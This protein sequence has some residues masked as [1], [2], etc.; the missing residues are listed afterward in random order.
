MPTPSEGG[1]W[2]ILGGA[3][4]PIHVGHCQ[5]AAQVQK[6]KSLQGVLFIPS[7]AH[8]FKGPRSGVSY[9]DRVTMLKLALKQHESFRLCP[10][11]SEMNLS[12]YSI[13][14]VS[15]LEQKY[16]EARFLFIIGAD[17]LA[18][19][20]RWKNPVE[21]LKRVEFVVA[22]RPGCQPVLPDM[23]PADRIELLATQLNQASSSDIRK[24]IKTGSGFDDWAPLVPP[25]VAGYIRDQ[26]LYR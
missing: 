15:A 11:E 9:D 23:V 21:L 22:A 13:D 17:N 12:G 8:P 20:S 5:I 3:F 14:T 16:P 10:I 6:L 1:K 4:D 18:D 26:G 19:L 24:R 7:Y 25:E 2:G